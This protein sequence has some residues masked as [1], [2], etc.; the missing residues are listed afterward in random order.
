MKVGDIVYYSTID[1]RTGVTG[2]FEIGEVTPAGMVK[3]KD[4]P[5]KE[6]ILS[7]ELTLMKWVP[8]SFEEAY[9]FFKLN[10]TCYALD[11]QNQWGYVDL[12]TKKFYTL[13]EV[14]K[15]EDCKGGG[16][17]FGKYIK[18]DENKNGFIEY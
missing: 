10:G 17:S 9:P 12:K 2:L 7:S 1:G 15:F 16:K 6:W 11:Y 4:C 5:I 14:A 3:L 13:E 18:S 8:F